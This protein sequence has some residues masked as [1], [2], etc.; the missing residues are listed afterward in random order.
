MRDFRKL[1]AWQKSHALAVCLHRI[2]AH[3]DFSTAPGLRAQLLRA[4]DSIPANVAEGAGKPSELDFARFLE[5]ALGSAREVDNHVML[6]AALGCI[7]DLSSASIL[8]DIDEVKRILFSLCRVV[9]VRAQ[10]R[11]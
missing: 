9:R 11:R 1:I 8:A 6:A 2:A 7:D 5:I 10:S 4:V 3:C